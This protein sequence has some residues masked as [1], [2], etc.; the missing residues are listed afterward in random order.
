MATLNVFRT[1]LMRSQAARYAMCAVLAC[2]A[3]VTL[4]IS[5]LVLAKPL[6][7]P[8]QAQTATPEA[9]MVGAGDIASC[10]YH[11]DYH[12]A[13]VVDSTITSAHAPMVRVFT[14][15]DNVYPDGTANQFKNCYDPTWGGSHLGSRK[16]ISRKI[17]NPNMW[18]LTRPAVGNHEYRTSGASAYFS[19]FGTDKAGDPSKGYYSYDLGSWHVVVLNSNC[20]KVG[21]CGALSPQGQW[22]KADLISQPPTTSCTLAYFHHPLFTS[23]TAQTNIVRP[24]WN[25][26][27]NEGADV[28]LSGHAHY[29]ERF[30]P[31]RP[32]GTKDEIYGIREFIVGTGGAD[33]DNPMRTQRAD[34]SQIDSEKPGEP[35]TTYYGVLKLDLHAGS[36]DWK[37]LPREQDA[38]DFTDLGSGSCHGEPP[39]VG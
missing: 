20:D 22:L 26:L 39:T 7:K 13:K 30:A 38:A 4:A 32:D 15:G 29:Y 28:I 2:A 21:G 17:V 35:G 5:L 24:F 3:A 11:R 12:T 6:E 25:T 34:H 23:S 18:T 14:L 1:V 36:Y 27:Y 10:S 31:L 33:P 9:T 16:D 37:F 19:Y 8:A